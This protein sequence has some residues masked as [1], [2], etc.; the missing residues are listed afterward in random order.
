MFK[1]DIRTTQ[2][3]REIDVPQQT[4]QRIVA[5]LSPSP[6]RKTLE[7]LAEYFS[8]SVDQLTGKKPLPD[9]LSSAS[10]TQTKSAS[11]QQH[12]PLIACADVERF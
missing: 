2:L 1:K 9:E 4:L 12:V 7:P 3:A 8:I 5:G 6:H 11:A 10:V